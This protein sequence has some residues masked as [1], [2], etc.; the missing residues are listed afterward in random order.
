MGSEEPVEFSQRE[1]L[2]QLDKTVSVQEVGRPRSD[3]GHPPHRCLDV[4][5]GYGV[6]TPFSLHGHS[7]WLL[8]GLSGLWVESVIWGRKHLTGSSDITRGSSPPRQ[9]PEAEGQGVG[10]CPDCGVFVGGRDGGG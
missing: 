1:I 6:G 9:G 3:G 10:C 5:L 2:H 8:W 7:C 4:G